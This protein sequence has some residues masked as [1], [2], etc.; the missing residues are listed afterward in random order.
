[1]MT[2][3]QAAS[4]V[5]PRGTST[6]A[7]VYYVDQ[8]HSGASDSND[9]SEE[10]PWL[11]V[12]KAANTATAGDIVYIKDGTYNE[13]VTANNSGSAG[14]PITFMAYPGHTPVLDG[15]GQGGWHGVF[16]IQGE[17]YIRLE[18]LEIRNNNTGWGVLV[19]HEDGNAGNAATN[20]ELVDLEVHHTGGEAV[21]IRGNAHH[22]LVQDCVVHDGDTYSGI[23]IYQW[24]GG[25]PHHVTVTGCTAYNYPGFAGI[26]SE[27][28]DDL[29]IE[30]NVIYNSALCIDIGSGD[31]NVIKNNVVN[32]C[33]TGIAL[34][35]NEDSEVYGNTIYNIGDE[36]IYSYYWIAH[37]EGHA[38]NK[39]YNNTVYNAGFGIYE[40]NRKDSRYSTGPTSDHEYYNN[41]FY[42]IGTHGS[43][44]TPFYFRGT[45][46]LEFY[47]NT[48]YLN[49]N[50][51]AIELLLG[52]IN[53]DIRNNIISTSGSGSPLIIDGS[54]NPGTVVD[55]NCYHN[56]SGN[57]TGPGA[58]SV[59]GDPKFTPDFHLQADSPC[60][61]TGVDLSAHH[62]T[63]KD[64]VSRPQGAGW[65]M[66]AYEFAPALA[67][68]GT[69]GNRVIFL[70]WTVSAAL[71]A[72]STWRISYYTDTVA[73]AVM[74]TDTLTHTARTF[75]LTD[76][77]NGHWYTVALSTVGVTPPL[78][79]TMAVQLVDNFVYLPI[80]I[81]EN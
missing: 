21:Q 39:W 50:Y 34:S 26:A 81:K 9:G 18:G 73:S 27:Q 28:A 2:L 57:S 74:V 52:A 12:Q 17:D 69:P 60:I 61:D 70:E 51:D 24:S 19:E 1:M 71:P 4:A 8:G 63:D 35:S 67:L 30:N 41:L 20:V 16:T 43:Y 15:T 46:D 76:L 13:I 66:G 77:E 38:R 80:I 75:I 56:R 36:A 78:S 7:G 33:D 45:T 64:G 48:L 42:D 23:D 65:D 79:D 37:G 6:L 31:D 54:S 14:S 40:S 62:T 32:D 11:T 72:T 55:Y 53:A 47:N 22:V 44:R 5:A 59:F 25:R 10:H 29:L 49:A 68:Y 58:H 3:G